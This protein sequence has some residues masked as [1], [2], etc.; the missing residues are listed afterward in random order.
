LH[1]SPSKKE[2][3]PIIIGISQ[4]CQKTQ[5]LAG[6]ELGT[7]MEISTI[8]PEKAAEYLRKVS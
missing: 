2:N 3:I 5:T 7:R 6:F 1:T 4:S 8:E